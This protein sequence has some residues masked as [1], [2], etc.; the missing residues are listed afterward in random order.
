MP[1]ETPTP[2]LPEPTF[3]LIPT[4]IFVGSAVLAGIVV[5]LIKIA[6]F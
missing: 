5:G 4:L 3:H 1:N 2:E 6:L